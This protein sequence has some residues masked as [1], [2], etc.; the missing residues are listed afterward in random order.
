M[1]RITFYELLKENEFNGKSEFDRL[2]S[3]FDR[4]IKIDDIY[5]ISHSLRSFINSNF[6]NIKNRRNAINLDDFEKATGIINLYSYEEIDLDYLLLY[7][8]Y[9]LYFI[10][11][12]LSWP[13]ELQKQI[14]RIKEQIN[15]I[16]EIVNYIPVKKDD[17][18]I[19]VPKNPAVLEVVETIEKD[20]AYE[21]L[22][23]NHHSLKGNLEGKKEVLVKIAKKLEP[24]EAEIRDLNPT[25]R[26]DIFYAFNNLN[27]R[28]NNSDSYD[29]GHYNEKFVNMSDSEKEKLYDCIYSYCLEAFLELENSY[30][31]KIIKELKQ[32]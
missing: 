14:Q 30:G 23:Y 13:F 29:A 11:Q 2:R 6:L 12:K 32:K 18:I 1:G 20:I 31:R 27:I 10:N 15:N 9:L 16:M 28:H 25:I 3:L 21:I 24:R 19:F 5:N 4:K 8:E 7:C 26:N 22:S 17:V